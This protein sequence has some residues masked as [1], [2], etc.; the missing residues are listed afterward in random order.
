MPLPVYASIRE[1]TLPLT[2]HFMLWPQPQSPHSE[3]LSTSP[4][5]LERRFEDVRQGGT[6][7][8][9]AAV[10]INHSLRESGLLRALAPDDLRLLLAVLSGVNGNGVFL[11][12]PELLA[13]ALGLSTGATRNRLERLQALRWNGGFLLTSHI[14]ESGLHFFQPSPH[15]LDERQS[16]I[17]PAPAHGERVEP[18][19]IASPSVVPA[20]ARQTSAR[21]EVIAHSR[22]TYT[23]PRAEVEAEI[24]RFLSPEWQ[25]TR[26][27]LGDRE[28]DEETSPPATPEAREWL[29][30]K[31]ALVAL[32]VPHHRADALLETHP[33]E[34]IA[35]QLEWL[36]FRQARSP[37]AYVVAAIEK[38]YAPPPAVSLQPAVSF[39]RAFEQ[40]EQQEA[41]GMVATDA[42]AMPQQQEH[43]EEPDGVGIEI[44]GIDVLS[45]RKETDETP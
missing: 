27:E 7:T 3:S 28:A 13:P 15:L 14:S 24:N 17:S 16:V 21:D 30:L 43:L 29:R 12:T 9:T 31:R 18:P 39:Q 11:A 35:R 5:V 22:A 44:Q 4:F 42:L 41:E 23:R 19:E 8:P 34:Q 45:S 37:A 10:W 38:D 25:K 1:T 32:G 6:F 20:R 36:P 26:P 40:N 2:F 33:P